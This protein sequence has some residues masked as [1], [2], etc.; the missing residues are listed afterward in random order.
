MKLKKCWTVEGKDK[1]R[2]VQGD[3]DKSFLLY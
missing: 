1:E 2:D 3:G